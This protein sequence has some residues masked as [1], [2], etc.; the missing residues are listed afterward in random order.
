MTVP[1]IDNRR[2]EILIV[3]DSPTQAE[4][5]QY[6]LERHDFAVSVAVNGSVA[7]TMIKERKPTLV[8]SDVVMPEMDGYQ[9]CREIKDDDRLKDLP[10]ILLTA[11]SDPRDVIRGLEC[12]ADNFITKPYDEQY[13]LSRIQYIL[14]NKHLQG[15]ELT[16][17]G[18]EVILA[19]EK[20]FIKSDRIQILNLLLSSYEAAIQKNVEL[21]RA[22]DE[23]ELLASRLEEKVK[24]RTVALTAKIKEGKQ[25][26]ER[27]RRSEK[28]TD[29]MNRI[30]NVFLTVGDEEMYGAVLAVI[31]EVMGSRFGVF[32]YL[33]DNGDL[34]IPSMSREVWKE[35]QVADKSLVFPPATWGESL[36][37][38]AIREKKAHY[39]NTNLRTPPGHL[40]IDNFLTT[41]ILFGNEAIGLISVANS[42][43]GYSEEDRSVQESISTRISPILN[44]RLQRDRQ[45]QARKQGEAERKKLEE[46]LHHAQK[47]EALGTLVGG[48]AHDFN[49]VLTA[50]IGFGNLMK[51]Q[52]DTAD[53]RA[54][55]L[56]QLLSAADRAANLTR[57]LLTFG[58][59]QEIEARPVML[60]AIIHSVEKMLE[61]L[62]RDNIELEIEPSDDDLMVM[63]DE[64]Q[65][66]QVLMN[67]ATNARD[68]MPA[69][70]RLTIASMPFE[71]DAEFD[72]THGYGLPGKY[73]LLTCSDSGDGMDEKTRQRIFEPFFTTKEVG[74]GTGLGLP[75]CYSIIKQHNGYINCYSEPGQGT[76]FRIYLPLIEA[77]SAEKLTSLPLTPPPQGDETILLAEDDLQVRMITRV[78]LETFGYKVIEAADGEEAVARFVEH[79]DEIRLVI[80][81]LVMPK[82]NG[83]EVYAAINKARPGVKALFTSG[84][85]EDVFHWKDIVEGG[86]AF[87]AKPV[88]PFALLWKVREV[89]D[90]GEIRKD[91]AS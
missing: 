72:K 61:R 6:T 76:T 9:L 80:I 62:L 4:E 70:G 67:L 7:L 28:F 43:N 42:A 1:D 57:S 34:V 16:Q 36:W 41:P 48:I 90:K 83:R 13:I 21:V 63:A 38:R 25:T 32:G 24:E 40:P 77:A 14:A 54:H 65:M 26:E 2:V 44:A 60:K 84:Y 68:A 49:N 15:V 56:E 52:T 33:A 19:G 91:L 17:L 71:M 75:V 31:L 86:F 12:G 69:G 82:K 39:S 27:L 59:K 53:P 58:R 64:G 87:I 81:D 37:G 45:E 79:K 30:A 20:Y 74:K 5:L 11:L 88:A 46:Q 73:A 85:S 8:I 51:L 23:L 50:I 35:C 47:M 3:E 55:H 29:A 66:Q 89:L 78:T 10:V 18:V 22:R